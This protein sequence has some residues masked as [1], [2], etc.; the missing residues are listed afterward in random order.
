MRHIISISHSC[1]L[2]K[3]AMALVIVMLRRLGV[4]SFVVA[5]D[6]SPCLLLHQDPNVS[7]AVIIRGL[8]SRSNL[9]YLG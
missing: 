8:S 1:L 3:H 6:T 7:V 9:I 2:A 5:E 4:G